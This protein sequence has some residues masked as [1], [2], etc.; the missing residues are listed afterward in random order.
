MNSAP[1]AFILTINETIKKYFILLNYNSTISQTIKPVI[2]MLKHLFLI[3][4]LSAC[5]P[6]GKA[7]IEKW[8]HAVDG[9]YAANISNDAKYSV[10]SSIHHGISLW[11][12]EKNALK[13]SWSLKQNSADN[14]V[15][16]ADISDNNSHVVTAN[17]NAFS[18]WDIDSGQSEGFWSIDAVSYTHLTLPTTPYV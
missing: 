1:R 5:Q 9:S 17:R 4:L 13:H 8:Q 11:D 2:R 6:G 14:L 7:P 15:L 12:L 16:V 18:L 10:V 3:V